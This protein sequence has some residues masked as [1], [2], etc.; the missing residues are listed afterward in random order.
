M[1]RQTTLLVALGV[2]AVWAL[3]LSLGGDGPLV[4]GSGRPA[5]AGAGKGAMPP[6]IELADLERRRSTFNASGGRN[7]F[8]FGEAPRPTPAAAAAPRKPKPRPQARTAVPVNRQQPG[9]GAAAP[10]PPPRASAPAGPTP[11]AV[12]FKFV[13]YMGE[14]ARL[15]GVFRVKTPDGEET[16]LAAEGEVLA[17]NFRVHRIGYEEVEIGYTQE[18]FLNERKVLPMGGQS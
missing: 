1:N 15:I 10:P 12:T 9:Q 11:P 17:E 16:V 14:Q 6:V 18:P 7:L 8:A 5:R 13:G 4:G 2:V 3:W